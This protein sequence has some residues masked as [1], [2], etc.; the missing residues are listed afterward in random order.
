MPT[1][2]DRSCVPTKT[3]PR[4]LAATKPANRHSKSHAEVGVDR[5]RSIP[6][7]LLRA[8]FLRVT[9]CD[10][11]SESN[12]LQATFLQATGTVGEQQGGIR[13]LPTSP[14]RIV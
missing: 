9:H 4:S 11:R 10:S 8:D 14:S 5:F 7:R 1:A 3:N 13:R 2:I 12:M 6:S